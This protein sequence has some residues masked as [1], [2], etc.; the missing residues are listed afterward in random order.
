MQEK[1][2][3]V[4]H[5]IGV[6]FTTRNRPKVLS[7]ALTYTKKFWPQGHEVQ[8]VVVD[9]DS[10]PENAK[11]NRE[12]CEKFG[13]KYIVNVMRKGIAKSKNVCLNAV[14]KCDYIFLFDDDAFPCKEQWADYYINTHKRTGIHH[15]NH[16]DKGVS[17]LGFIKEVNG[18]N[19]FENTGGTLLFLT[20]QAFKKVG[21][22]NPNFKIYGMDHP[23]YTRRMFMAGLHNGY[24]M[25]V[26]P[27][28]SPEFIYSLDFNLNIF[29]QQFTPIDEAK[30]IGFDDF[31]KSDFTSSLADELDKVQEYIEENMKIYNQNIVIYRPI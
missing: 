20:Q 9:D 25:Y 3:I 19:E 10:T 23:D 26:S 4:S 22:F 29:G 21:G 7:L 12:A 15:F 1:N 31:S 2:T 18:V 16:L 14:K 5:R 8:L 13:A 17:G 27:S 11:L 28:R 24:G 6:A 30:N